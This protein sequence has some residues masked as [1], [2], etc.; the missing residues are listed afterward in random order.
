MSTEENPTEV[1]G[2]SILLSQIE[3]ENFKSVTSQTVALRPLSV[4]V[5]PNS[6]GKT[7]VIQSILMR[8]HPPGGMDSGLISLNDDATKL[9]SMELVRRES[10]PAG[11]M[12][13]VGGELSLRID[14]AAAPFL[15]RSSLEEL[16]RLRRA[17]M[18]ERGSGPEGVEALN[19]ARIAWTLL[20]ETPIADEDDAPPGTAIV[21]S[22]HM[23]A[24]FCPADRAEH[25]HLLARAAVED[26]DEDYTPILPVAIISARFDHH[27]EAPFEDEPGSYRERRFLFRPESSEPNGRVSHPALD[28][29]FGWMGPSCDVAY[30][31]PRRGYP[32]HIWCSASTKELVV[33][34]L[35]KAWEWKN[36]QEF[37]EMQGKKERTGTEIEVPELNDEEMEEAWSETWALLEREV[38]PQARDWVNT[39]FGYLAARSASDDGTLLVDRF[40]WMWFVDKNS[41]PAED[42]DELGGYLSDLLD[43]AT[44]DED[45][46]PEEVRSPTIGPDLDTNLLNIFTDCYDED[47]ARLTDLIL[48]RV[49]EP[50]FAEGVWLEQNAS[51][52]FR[53]LAYTIENYFN[54]HVFHVGPLRAA[55]QTS[56]EISRAETRRNHVEDDGRNTINRLIHRSTTEVV[57]PSLHGEH[58]TVPLKEAVS[59]WMGEGEDGHGLRQFSDYE[60][61]SFLDVIETF[62]VH[63]KG[64]KTPRHL[65]E[66]GIG[67][68]QVLPVVVQCLLASPGELVLLQ[69]P[70]LHLHPA[71]QQRLGDFLLACARSGRQIILET[72]SEYLISRLAL[73]VAEDPTGQIGDDLFNV[74][75]TEKGDNGTEYKQADI[76][77]YG[78]I[79]WPTDFFDEGAS[80]AYNIL[81]AGLEKQKRHLLDAAQATDEAS[82]GSA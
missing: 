44:S 34:N 6:A 38:V 50:P 61:D 5:G 49:V 51:Q 52:T 2:P 36:S 58:E 17:A 39:Y 82:E 80:E 54:N 24:A 48:D 43:W 3:L 63:Q 14:D 9:H 7:T 19:E 55:P 28:R 78:S 41:Y 64:L 21:H 60:S 32:S 72:H 10:A 15:H 12:V 53:T 8:V 73:R 33:R 75:L 31:N 67:V 20:L 57:C 18:G 42:E 68:S 79:K 74:L 29:P 40:P 13:A 56:Y 65:S 81:R 77:R 69:Q 70:E 16:H 1:E 22:A 11:E 71:L 37:E 66:L 30:S 25:G 4:F 46:E 35:L 45:D 62:Q 27:G 23:M 26:E 47:P 76:D 59:R